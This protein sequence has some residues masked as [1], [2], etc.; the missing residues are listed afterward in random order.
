MNLSQTEGRKSGK[1][2]YCTDVDKGETTLVGNGDIRCASEGGSEYVAGDGK[3]WGSGGSEWVDAGEGLGADP[4]VQTEKC[5]CVVTWTWRSPPAAH[6]FGGGESGRLAAF[7]GVVNREAECELAVKIWV[8]N[9]RGP[10]LAGLDEK[11]N[12]GFSWPGARDK[13]NAI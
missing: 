10:G 7:F 2:T 9:G 5:A 13:Y 8:E 4:E 3:T 1:W 6:G 11:S 12:T